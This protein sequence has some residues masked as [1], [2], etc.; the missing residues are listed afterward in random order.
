MVA[1]P[2]P[3]PGSIDSP[4]RGLRSFSASDEDAALFFGRDREQELIVANLLASRLTLLYGQSGIGKSS[5]LCAGVV[6]R[7]RQPAPSTLAAP[8]YA[9]VYVGEWHADPHTAILE[10]VRRE[11]RRLT[12]RDW[13][14]T[15]PDAP[16]DEAL[17]EW[18]ERLD[19]Q[20]LLVLD[21]FEQYFLYNPPARSR[22]V[23]R[24]LADAIARPDL[25]LRCLMSLREDAL[26]GLDRFKGEIPNLFDN[27][28]RLDGLTEDA[29]LEAIA[30]PVARYNEG[31]RPDLPTVELEPG[32]AEAVVGGLQ[33]EVSPLA[34]GRGV[35]LALAQTRAGDERIEPAHLQLVMEALWIHERAEG[36]PVLRAAT[37]AAMG[38][39]AEIVRSHVESGLD[40]LPARQRL[41]AARTIRYLITP[42][43]TKIAHTPADLAT[44][45]EVPEADVAETLER[46]CALRIMRPL[47]PPEGSQE[48]RYEVFHDLLAEP[49]L[50]W[51]A[52]FEAQRL[53]SRMRWLLAS[54]VAAAAA[55]LAIAA[56]SIDPTPLRHLELRTLDA[57][58]A[59]R[60]TIPPDRDIVI[61]DLD[62]RSLEVLGKG[63]KTVA[64]RPEYARLFDLLLAG[65][66]KAIADDI[67][68]EAR[69]DERQLLRAIRRANGRIVLSAE[70][71]DTEGDVALFGRE[72]V[73]GS[74][75]LLEELHAPA[76]YDSFPLDPGRVYRRMWSHPPQS[77]LPSLS[78]KTAEIAAHRPVA[79]FAG[80][81]L[82][83]YH[84]PPRTFTT[85][86]MIRVLHGQVPLG[87]F[88][89]KIVVFGT[90]V[91]AGED[92]HRTSV[93]GQKTMPGDEI[94]ANAISTVRHGPA[95]RD[96]SA[97]ITILLIL[98][99]SLIPL[100]AMPC[101]W[102]AALT[103]FAGAA[104]A[105]LI[106]V[107]LL[108]DGG[109]YI[110]LVYPLLALAL[111]GIG[112]LVARI[113]IARQ[114]D[115]RQ[116]RKMA[117]L[118]PAGTGS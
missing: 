64:L 9:A 99:L 56:Y 108:F 92:L 105:C 59:V 2:S 20:L 103:I 33:R 107:Q 43:G 116:Q 82:I 112:T 41:I 52:R 110:Q 5:I 74:K 51:R 48:R 86:S 26:V 19:A 45:T 62:K 100:L 96:A 89:D 57:R 8:R 30:R 78:V 76:G 25:R 46:L 28:L 90:S 95:L 93:T 36:S 35:P 49:I 94:Q 58:F 44:Y 29:A 22:S 109:L 117:G 83:D 68:F 3:E 10:R 11:A 102:W 88:K 115:P 42:S 70:R 7:L 13:E 50:E 24:G 4:Y 72:G 79:R 77:K 60:G 91:P 27:R 55:A 16:L 21:Q 47:A 61:V 118:A 32:L 101:P 75:K 18:T 40:G 65:R 15:D 84:G 17:R 23:D 81:I 104:G 80:E 97:G 113:F 34:R 71:F 66:P 98:A 54:L 37:L 39:C 53:R 87:L 6:H 1:S 85:V 38:G 73:N 69:G 31:R 63:R 67:E 106:L 111:A 14:P 114:A 12:G